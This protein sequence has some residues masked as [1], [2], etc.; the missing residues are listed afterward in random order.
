M[1]KLITVASD[2]FAEGESIPPAHTCDGQD[3]SPRIMIF[4]LPPDTASWAVLCDDPDAPAGDWVHWLVF[5]LP[6]TLVELPQGAT[7]EVLALEGGVTG[8]NSWG[9]SRWQGPCPPSG[10]HRYFFKIFALDTVL[11]LPPGTDKAHFLAK[12][13]GHV[14]AHG[15]LMGRYERTR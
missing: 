5:N 4:D 6:P 8:A 13:K 3:L 7:P 10:Q 15:M 2:A 9:N 11:E 12:S 1:S 14:L